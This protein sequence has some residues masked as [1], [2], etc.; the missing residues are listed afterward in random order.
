MDDV[1]FRK[2]LD[3]FELSW[4]GYRKV[5]KGVKKRLGRHMELL[6]RRTVDDF[7]VL[8][9]EGPRALATTRELLTVTISRFFRDRRLWETLGRDVLPGLCAGREGP[10][11]VWHA[12]CS[13]GEEVYSL[14]IL[15]DQVP[16]TWPQAAPLEIWATDLDPVVL[17]RG[18]DAVY[19]PRSL[20][21]LDASLRAAYFDV[22]AQGFA[23]RGELRAGIHWL[24]HDFVRED[25]PGMAFDL[26][27]LRNNLLTYYQPQVVGP[28]LA[29]IVASLKNGGYLIVGNHEKIDA[30]AVPLVP[31]GTE[32]SILCK[33]VSA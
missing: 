32:P 15:W 4:E 11:R 7:L 19:P 12:G 5:R 18:R 10:V 25:P 17:S 1:S 22:L 14:K 30:Y 26:I 16:K 2:I 8:L 9:R 24:Q 23:V 21:E 20:R 6:G 31:W 13:C 29:R 33:A 27:F 28:V 3:F